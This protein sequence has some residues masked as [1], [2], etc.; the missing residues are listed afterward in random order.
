MTTTTFKLYG[1]D[2]ETEMVVFPSKFEVCHRCRGEGKHVNPNIDGDSGIS[3]EDFDRD[4]D[5]REDYFSGVYDIPCL[6]CKGLRV[7][8]VIDE[9]RLTPELKVK[10]EQ[11]EA[12]WREESEYNQLVRM[13]RM[14]GC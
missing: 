13:E 5:F 4:P 6:D 10:L 8:A 3:Q 1:E 9:D 11:L 14:M 7:T 12:Q 2:G